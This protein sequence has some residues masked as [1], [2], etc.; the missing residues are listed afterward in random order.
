LEAGAQIL[1]AGGAGVASCEEKP[2]LPRARDN[3]F[4]MVPNDPLQGTAELL[5]QAGGA[6]MEIYPTKCK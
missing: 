1:A 5:N 6:S 4:Q 2:G 3:L